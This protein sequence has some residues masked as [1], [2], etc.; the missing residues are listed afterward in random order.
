MKIYERLTFGSVP[1]GW[2][3]IPSLSSNDVLSFRFHICWSSLSK[4]FSTIVLVKSLSQRYLGHFCCN[5]CIPLYHSITQFW[6]PTRLL[7]SLH[8]IRSFLAGILRQIIHQK[9]PNSSKKRHTKLVSKR[10]IVE[11]FY[12]TLYFLD[13]FR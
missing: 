5:S 1:S 4:P 2:A 11:F 7:H 13:I 9:A 12:L 3:P 10:Q 8:A 6:Q